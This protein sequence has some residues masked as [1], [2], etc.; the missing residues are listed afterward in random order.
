MSV[1]DLFDWESEMEM[2]SEV[3]DI[4]DLEEENS[5]VLVPL[6]VMIRSSD[7]DDVVIV[8]DAVAMDE[9]DSVS[10]YNTDAEST[11]EDSAI[12]ESSSDEESGDEDEEQ[13]I[14]IAEYRDSHLSKGSDSDSE[15]EEDGRFTNLNLFYI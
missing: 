2:D 12:F 11:S 1:S 10:D 13:A 7:D 15:P 4:E 3:T 5:V 6:Q 9:V 8:D 14:I